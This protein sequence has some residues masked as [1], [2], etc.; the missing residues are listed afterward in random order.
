MERHKYIPGLSAIKTEVQLNEKN[1]TISNDT[2]NRDYVVKTGIRY[3]ESGLSEDEAIEKLMNDEIV[4]KFEYLK[5]NG[6]D[7]KNCFKNWIKSGK[8]CQARQNQK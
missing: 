5:N 8:K 1:K 3:M 6:V 7:I 2:Q 4:Q